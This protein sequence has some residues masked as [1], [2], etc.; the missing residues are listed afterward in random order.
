MRAHISDSGKFV[1]LRTKAVVAMCGTFG[2]ELD[3]S[4]L[5]E[6]E[7]D[8]C[9]EQSGLFRKYYPIIFGGD[10]YRL[11][12]PFEAGNMTAWQH[13]TKDKKESLLSFKISYSLFC[14]PTHSFAPA[15]YNER[16]AET[17]LPAAIYERRHY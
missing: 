16:Q 8:I 11:S 4:K 6:D 1:P 2:Y 10:Y 15:L 14:H 5:S 9:R 3:A 17:I 7:Q 13:V 12:N